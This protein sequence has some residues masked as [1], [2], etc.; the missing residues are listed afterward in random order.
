M[1]DRHH[2][3]SGT[4]QY[5]SEGAVV[6]TRA[7]RVR[8]RNENGVHRF[9][10]IPYAAAP[11]G[12]NRF[13]PPNPAP[14][15]AGVRDAGA[16]G[17][18]PPQLPTPPPL[19]AFLPTV[20]GADYLNVNVWTSQPGD[21]RQP[22]M[23]WIPGGGF[24]TGN[25]VIYDGSRFARDGVVLVAINYRLGAEGFLV[26]DDDIA[27]VGLLD[28]IAALEWVHDN[29]AAFGGDPD[30]VTVFG[31]SS[32]AMSVGTLLTMPNARGLFRRAIMQSGAGNLCYS[33]DT[34]REIG[35]RVADMLGVAPTREAVA[36]AGVDRLLAAQLSV[37]GDL[38]RTPDPQR[39]GAEPGARVNMWRPTVDGVTLPRVPLEAIASG[40]GSDVDVLIGQNAEEGRL[41]LVPFAGLD[42]VTDAAFLDALRLYR[43]PDSAATDYRTAYP[44]ATPGEL[45]AILQG[46]WF[47]RIPAIRLAEARADAAARTHMYE[48]TWRSPQF[49][50]HLGACH[51]LEIPFVFDLLD[52]PVMRWVTGP[53]PPQPLADLMHSTWVRFAATGE[54]PWPRYEPARRTT[55]CF[56]ADPVVR[57]DPSPIRATWAGVDLT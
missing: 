39:W 27:N 25:N 19:D 31:Q 3:P 18:T 30:N 29:I 49:D 45:L 7:G 41:S 26:L 4:D 36:E 34:G 47:Y 52:D 21:A 22:V 14:P 40:A 17:P 5:S 6:T 20:A 11:S 37:A 33:L 44:D 43:L 13:L 1:R 55:M 57:D 8:G 48:F 28:Q 2:P 12:P 56:D 38:A 51:F 50:G 23:V 10:G 9:L 15:W 53:N 24:D 16:D 32:G 46:D 35:H 42:S 54:V